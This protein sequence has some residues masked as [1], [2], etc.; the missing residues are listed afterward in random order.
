[1]SQ[2]KVLL[3]LI[4]QSLGKW[5]KYIIG[6]KELRTFCDISDYVLQ[7]FLELYYEKSRRKFGDVG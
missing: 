1:M 4:V 2:Y 7:K 5:L 3:I 6:S